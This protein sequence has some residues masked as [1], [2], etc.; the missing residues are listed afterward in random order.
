MKIKTPNTR[1]IDSHWIGNKE[2]HD[3]NTIKNDV[4]MIQL[5]RYQSY[6]AFAWQDVN[7]LMTAAMLQ[8][9]G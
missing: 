5:A 2:K 3:S 7:R 6:V 4:L 1:L 8:D 9:D